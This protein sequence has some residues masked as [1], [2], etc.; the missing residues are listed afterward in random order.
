[1]AKCGGYRTVFTVTV[2]S[3]VE[4]SEGISL[5]GLES[6][7]TNGDWVGQVEKHATTALTR[8][9][10]AAALADQGADPELS[11][12]WAALEDGR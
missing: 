3:D 1:M 10:M 6:Q 11:S 4:P 12:M 9:G 8:K 2:L 7:I 5:E